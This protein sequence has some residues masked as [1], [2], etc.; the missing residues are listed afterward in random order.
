MCPR[1]TPSPSWSPA[2]RTIGKTA[3][4]ISDHEK[5]RP[6]ETRWT[7]KF[8]KLRAEYASVYGEDVR[9]I[10]RWIHKN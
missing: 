9:T 1:L 6:H 8:E 10:K 2:W 3:N 5:K 4:Q 7:A